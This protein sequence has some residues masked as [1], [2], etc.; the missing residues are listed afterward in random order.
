MRS[1][2][3]RSARMSGGKD[4][5]GGDLERRYRRVLRLLP[6]WY[7]RE[8]EADMVA[9]FLDSWLTGDPETDEYLT[10]VA[11]P[12]LAETASVVSL[13]GRL[14]LGGAGTPRR[15]FAWGQATRR[16]VLVL[17]L[18]QA[19]RGLDVLLLTA[20][21]RH[22]LGWLPAP[23]AG[24]AVATPGGILPPAAWYLVAYAWMVSFAALLL[25]QYRTA[26]LIAAFAIVP[27]LVW[28]LEGEFTGA[29]RS[30][31]GPWSFWVLL[32][33]APVLAMSAFHR[34][35][36]PAA[37]R[38]WLLALP[39]ACLVVCGPP[40]VLLATGHSA[41][42][43]DFSGLCCVL[44]ALAC[45]AR[46]P[47]AW[48]RRGAGSGVWSLTLMLLAADAGT[49]RIFSVTDYLGDP[50]LIAVS[51]AELLILAIAAAL[52]APDAARA[53]S[54]VPAMP[55]RPYSYPSQ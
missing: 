3:M 19:A 18:L 49:Y 41:W 7:R 23:P 47:L 9:A 51:L 5:T 30:P 39:A 33:L 8:W 53:Q 28:L 25:R 24:L 50:H 48:S 43:P 27:D 26:Q 32:N 52:L 38:P 2:R 37:S 29:L 35:A 13:A 16:A 42:L 17:T 46:A 45:L 15:Y 14:Y 11:R 54:A 1:G 22:L 21:S 34:D 6:A 10:A 20:W 36:P 55:A 44:V 12:G 4:V 40:V 31:I